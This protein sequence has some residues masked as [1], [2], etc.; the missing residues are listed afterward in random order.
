M[1]SASSVPR[2]LKNLKDV[3]HHKEDYT[4]C[5]KLEMKVN[6]LNTEELFKAEKE[7]PV[8]S[9]IAPKVGKLKLEANVFENAVSEESVTKSPEIKVGKIDVENI[10]KARTPDKEEENRDSL[11]VGKLNKNVYS[12]R[13]D[14]S[15]E[16][17]REVKV[18]KLDTEEM[19][20]P[21]EEAS[22]ELLNICKPGKLS[23]DKL[24]ISSNIGIQVKSTTQL[25]ISKFSR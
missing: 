16:V 1:I 7:E 23:E 22:R 18:G 14:D 9:N 15:R 21:A 2:K 6:K 19:F 5:T 12:P 20:K 11:K 13:S 24:R 4:D 10:F 3:F 17:S 25:L 8:K